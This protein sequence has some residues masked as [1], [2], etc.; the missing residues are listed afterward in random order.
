MI[1]WHR[2]GSHPATVLLK[3]IGQTLS[4]WRVLLR[5][6]PG[7]VFVMSPPPAAVVAVY[8]YC[9]LA[10]TPFVIDAHSGAFQNPRWRHFQRLHFWLCRRA[11]S[12]IVSNSSLADLVAANGGRATVVPDVPV[13]FEA[14]DQ[15]LPRR[16]EV[17]FV[18][19]VTSFDRDEPIGAMVEA[20]RRL[21]QFP[22]LMTGNPS[23]G[24]RVLPQDLPPNLTLTGFIDVSRYGVLLQTAGAVMTLTTQE[25]TMQR[26]AYEAIYQGTPVIVSNSLL[27]RESF[28]EGAVHVD[29]SPEAIVD[30]VLTI[31]KDVATFRQ[32]AD[33]LRRRKEQRW[34]NT[35]ESLIQLIRP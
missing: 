4:T 7:A 25:N 32:Q 8:V 33:R 16:Q 14:G 31:E 30:A 20:A 28:D 34:V 13:R 3:Y 22:F 1:Y 24:R 15:S 9:C 12:T 23:R 2:L 19:C 11:A 6:R 29:N 10:R 18:V 21:P 5:E 35:K 27:L 26:G 17:F